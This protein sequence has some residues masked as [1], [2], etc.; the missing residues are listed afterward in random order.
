MVKV[1]CL[2]AF[3]FEGRNVRPDE[4]VEVLP[5]LAR[6]LERARRAVPLAPHPQP[7]PKEFNR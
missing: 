1:R 4:T 5:Q 6:V 2:R 3:W 7:I